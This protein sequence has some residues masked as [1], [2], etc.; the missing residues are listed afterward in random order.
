MSTRI[1]DRSA[2]ARASR[3]ATSA[4]LALTVAATAACSS[5]LDVK[6]PASVTDEA[7]SDPTLVPALAA[8]AI[9]TLQCG[10]VNF[11]GTAGMLSG[12]YLS[13][14]GF[15]NNH[16]WEWRSVGDILNSPG[17]C[18]YG[19][20][21]TYMGFYTPLQQARFQLEDTFQRLDKFTD[22]DVP[23]RA[24]MMAQMRAYVGYAYL[25]LA[26]GMCDMA[27][28]GGPKLTRDQVL[29]MAEDRFTDAIARANAV[30]DQ[31]LL[32]MAR[33]GRARARLDLKKLPD[34]A[35]DATL[36]PASFVRNVEFTEGGDARR[37][38]RIYNLT[39]RNDY[40][41][42]AD[43]YRNMTVNGV[44]GSVPDP[45]VKVKAT[46][47]LRNGADGITPMWQQQKY[48]AQTGGT[49]IPLASWNEAQL[50]Y[51]EAIGGQQGFDA[52]NRVRT[53]NNVPTLAGPPPT[54]QAYTDLVLEERRRQLFSEG[55]RYVDML[56][57]NLPFTKGVNRK[58]QIY[59]DLTCVPLPNVETFNN[60]NFKG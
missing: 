40:L 57:Y 4:L 43:A 30:N 53:A 60:P 41:S 22:A 17:D 34:A 31:S 29:A 20:G 55:Q 27:I 5:L 16:T 6:N 52:I 24:L 32:N 11:V 59:S 28:D 1:N 18:N 37:E 7:L 8:A 3:L 25:L 51:A 19:R 35:A 49:P 23:N 38:N 44:S 46:S 45:R 47:P 54:G 33:V 13:A 9:Q 50:I 10:V 21:S 14:N 2:A 12:E 15:V 48:I 39:I 36:V 26:E 56:R 58:G 42:V